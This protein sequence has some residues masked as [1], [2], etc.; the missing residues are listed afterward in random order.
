MK[1]AFSR[2]VQLLNNVKSEFN[3]QAAQKKLLLIEIL[4]RLKP[5]SFKS[6]KQYHDI[7]LFISAFPDSQKLAD[8]TSEELLRLK[9]LLLVRGKKINLKNTGLEYTLLCFKPSLDAL[10]WLLNHSGDLRFNVKSKKK[11]EEITALLYTKTEWDSLLDTDISF[12]NWMK[13]LAGKEKKQP[14]A[15][16]NAWLIR[17]E[18]L[19]AAPAVRDFLFESLSIKTTCTVNQNLSITSNRFVSGRSYFHQQKPGLKQNEK[20]KPVYLNDRTSAR[21]LDSIRA[22]LYVRQKETD[23]VTYADERFMEAYETEDGFTVYLLSTK[24]EYRLP[25]ESNIGYMVYSNGIPVCYGGGWIFYE[26][27]EFGINIFEQFRGGHSARIL[28]VLINVYKQHYG[29]KSFVIPPYQFG[30]GNREGIKSGAFWFYYKMGFRPVNKELKLLAEREWKKIKKNKSYR[31]PEN[32]LLRFTE[33]PVIFKLENNLQI[34]ELKNLSHSAINWIAENFDGNQTEASKKAAN[35]LLKKADINRKGWNASEKN[36]FQD[37]APFICMI[38]GWENWKQSEL[39]QAVMTLKEKGNN[40][41]CFIRLLQ[42]HDMLRME[43]LK[44]SK[45]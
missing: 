19:N 15:I 18:K 17:F 8:K 1:Y 34:P 43:L 23:T 38:P 11:T 20:L 26:R 5:D 36:F 21:T 37:L 14:S 29:I 40:E 7:L 4:A 12:H 2:K 3:A 22:A 6:L 35:R 39:K 24:P 27:C 16:L 10:L 13:Q 33:S 45:G 9:R 41:H 32:I 25:L 31:T 30:D 42:Q 44:L 28:N